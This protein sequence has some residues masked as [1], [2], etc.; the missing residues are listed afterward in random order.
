MVGKPSEIFE[1]SPCMMVASPR[2]YHIPFAVNSLGQAVLAL[3]FF[4]NGAPGAA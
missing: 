2:S 4:E 3:S 1:Q